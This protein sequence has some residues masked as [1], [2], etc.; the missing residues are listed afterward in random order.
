MGKRRELLDNWRAGLGLEQPGG[1]VV[2][3]TTAELRDLIAGAEQRGREDGIVQLT[4]ATQDSWKLRY[5]AE[6]YEK[7]LLDERKIC[8]G[9]VESCLRAATGPAD[10]QYNMGVEDALYLLRRGHE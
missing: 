9:I 4:V 10:E 3:A 5:R 1:F 7:G 2:H 6:Y 8:I